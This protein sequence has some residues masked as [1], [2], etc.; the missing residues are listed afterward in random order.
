MHAIPLTN[1]EN[2]MMQE[3]ALCPEHL[4]KQFVH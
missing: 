4:I 2:F 1:E 3:I